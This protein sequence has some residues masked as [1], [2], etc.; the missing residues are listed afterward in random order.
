MIWKNH[1]SDDGTAILYL[2]D[3]FFPQMTVLHLLLLVFCPTITVARSTGA[4]SSACNHLR[5]IHSGSSPDTGPS[6]YSIEVTDTE[7]SGGVPITGRFICN[8]FIMN[9]PS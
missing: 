7:Y 6:P 9:D 5:P 3:T 2:F 1:V 4:P 8:G